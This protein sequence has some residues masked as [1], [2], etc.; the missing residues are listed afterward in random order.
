MTQAQEELRK[1]GEDLKHLVT[2][3]VQAKK[4]RDNAQSLSKDLRQRKLPKG[5]LDRI[6]GAVSLFQA[7]FLMERESLLEYHVRY[8]PFSDRTKASF[9]L[10]GIITI[11]DLITKTKAD[12]LWIDNIGPKS[13]EEI[14]LILSMLNLSLKP[15][16]EEE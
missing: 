1:N 4:E 2:T 6:L 8:L 10:Y 13:I 3:L 11:H 16:G 12:L 5:L 15:Q 7:L 9:A 14:V